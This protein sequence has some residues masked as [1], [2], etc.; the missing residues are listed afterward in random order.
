MKTFRAY[1]LDHNG[2]ITWGEWIEA[3]DEQ[4]AMLKAKDLCRED[5]PKVEL[6]QG[7]KKIGAELCGDEPPP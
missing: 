3:V 1:L 4:H 5:S 6:W 7:S 2:K